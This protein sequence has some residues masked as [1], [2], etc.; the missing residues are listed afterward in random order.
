[1]TLPREVM[2]DLLTIYLAGEASPATRTLVETYARED[3]DF[4]H[5][6]NASQSLDLPAF[7]VPDQDRKRLQTLKLVR[8]YI[9]LRTLFL[10]MGIAFTLI[11]FS[12][13][14]QNGAVTF[15]LLRDSPGLG[16]AFLSI[17]A[18]SWTAFY[19]MR[20]EIRKAGL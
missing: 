19:I 8:Q 12:L 4:A 17:A 1:M 2:N 18:A 6:L 16:Y 11:P 5:S 7:E 15:L 10:A 20:R 13:T 9:F 14:I 3:A